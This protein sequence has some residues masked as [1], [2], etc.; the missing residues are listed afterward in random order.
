MDFN[1][2]QAA[3]ISTAIYPSKYKIIYPALGLAGEAGE[4]VEKVKKMIR[5]DG[6]VLT[7]E[8]R[9]G[10]KKELGGQLWYI[11]TL[12][13]DCNLNLNDVAEANIEQ[14]RDRMERNV[15][16]GDGDNR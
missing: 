15:I 13:H 12:A 9:E 5:D 3:A 11:A 16:H 2:Y 1:E 6:E 7:E 8:R 14:L 10:I 4:T